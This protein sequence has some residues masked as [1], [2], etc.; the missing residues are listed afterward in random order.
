MFGRKKSQMETTL[1]PES[2]TCCY[3]NS[4]V[5]FH[6]PKAN[7]CQICGLANTIDAAK[8]N[9]VGLLVSLG[10]KHIPDDINATLWG[11]ELH[12]GFNQSIFDGTMDRGKGS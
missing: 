6:Q 4:T 3:E 7:F 9:D 11:Q 10:F 8:C 5:V 12:Q 1:S 2:V